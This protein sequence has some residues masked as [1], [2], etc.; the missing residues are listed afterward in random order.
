MERPKVTEITKVV[1]EADIVKTIFLKSEMQPKPGQF[2]MVWIPGINEKPYA[3][4][5]IDTAKGEIGITVVPIGAFSQKLCSMKAGEKLGLRGPYGK[6]YNLEKGLKNII[7]VGGGCGAASLTVLAEEAL[8]LGT[9][10]KFI[11]GAKNRCNLI[12]TERLKKLLGKN[13]IMTTDDGSAG[14]KGFATEALKR[15]IADE[16]VDKVFACGPEKMLKAV[17]DIGL[18][19][20]LPGE[21]SMERYMK[22]GFGICGHCSVDPVGIRLCVEGPVLSFET[23]AKITEF[24]NY[25]RTKSSRKEKM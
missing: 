24:G 17:V 18:K 3:A 9:N 8:K 11:L 15:L 16:R 4:S 10:V 7:L 19:N 22:C 13:F 12:Y 1:H 25:F 6:G 21:V 5:Y 23:A 2:I 20:K 14:E